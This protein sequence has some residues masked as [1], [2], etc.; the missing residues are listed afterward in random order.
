MSDTPDDEDH[1]PSETPPH[2]PPLLDYPSRPTHPPELDTEPWS[3]VGRALA[4]V[5]GVMLALFLI[6]VA[7]CGVLPR[8]CG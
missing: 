6:F 5:F 3:E 4:V 1:V 2:K 8:G 7:I